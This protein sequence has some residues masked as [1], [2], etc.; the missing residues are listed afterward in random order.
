MAL[1]IYEKQALKEFADKYVSE[2]RKAIYK[3]KV[4]RRRTLLPTR[5]SAPVNATGSLAKS[6]KYKMRS[7]GN[8]DF[9]SNNYL[10]WLIYGRRPNTKPIP[11]RRK[12]SSGGGKSE[13]ISSIES[14]M[15]AK[16]INT[17]E[18][19]PFA[20]AN[21]IAKNGSS[22]YRRYK[23]QQ[24]NLLNDIPID[25]MLNELYSKMGDGYIQ[26]INYSILQ[27]VLIEDLNFEL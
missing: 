7:N 3:K 22:I 13:F 18:V 4:A 11:K 16:G 17:N 2:V 24:S 26:V 23:G 20:I 5:F 10:Y 15:K 1:S 9:I 14:W 21:S 27:N 12:G 6:I 25:E 19:S 8:V